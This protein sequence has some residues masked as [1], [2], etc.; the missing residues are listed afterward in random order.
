MFEFKCFEY[1]K[2]LEQNPNNEKLHDEFITFL[3]QNKDKVEQ[4]IIQNS[5][6]P[7]QKEILMHT[8]QQIDSS[9]ISSQ[10]SSSLNS[11]GT[12]F[13]NTTFESNAPQLSGDDFS[14][15]ILQTFDQW[16]A[17]YLKLQSVTPK[18]IEITEQFIRDNLFTHFD[19]VTTFNFL[20]T[21]SNEVFVKFKNH[22]LNVCA[23]MFIE[24][25]Q[26]EIDTLKQSKSFFS[27]FIAQLRLERE[28]KK[29]AHKKFDLNHMRE[30][31]SASRQLR[32]E[33]A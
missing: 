28:Q 23:I 9:G 21:N 1:L 32:G 25:L 19:N 3:S 15:R 5:L 16:K 33:A 10:Q 29:L 20:P 31:L 4:F 18:C 12:S 22:I 14:N 30:V 11:S 27:R 8:M 7:Q 26:E 24:Q 17:E 6:Q 2:E 13:S